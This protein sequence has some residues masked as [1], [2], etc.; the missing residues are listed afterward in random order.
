[1]A[2]GEEGEEE[3]WDA[4]GGGC[5]WGVKGGGEGADGKSWRHGEEDKW[6]DD[7]LLM[8][9][10]DASSEAAEDVECSIGGAEK[11]RRNV[12]LEHAV[13]LYGWRLYPRFRSLAS[14]SSEEFEAS[15]V[16]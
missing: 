5:R 7:G 8:D 11:S 4:G 3:G 15:L 14:T 6:S 2:G 9:V 1:M 12:M 13:E 10:S 16:G